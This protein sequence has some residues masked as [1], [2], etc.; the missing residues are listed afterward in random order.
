M[1]MKRRTL[2]SL[3]ITELTVLQVRMYYSS[4]NR[5]LNAADLGLKGNCPFF[6]TVITFWVFMI[7]RT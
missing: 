6:A 2:V 5:S 3:L 4:C 1:P 7:L